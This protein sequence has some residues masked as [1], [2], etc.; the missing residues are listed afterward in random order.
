MTCRQGCW[1]IG[2]IATLCLTRPLHAQHFGGG[3]DFE[4]LGLRSLARSLGVGPGPGYHA[5]A[6]GPRHANNYY[7]VTQGASGYP[8]EP[9]YRPQ[10]YSEGAYWTPPHQSDQNSWNLRYPQH[11][12]A[13]VAPSESPNSQEP[14][15]T[16]EKPEPLPPSTRAPSS[17]A[18]DDNAEGSLIDELLK[19]QD[20]DE[21][22]LFDEL[23]PVSPSDLPT[24]A[25]PQ[26]NNISGPG[27]WW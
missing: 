14:K 1:A 15:R 13:P 20:E 24:P 2:L 10:L 6:C 26:A 22:D 12:T 8:L 3:Y 16:T 4:P 27:T 17:K 21:S 25:P 23:Q 7:R 18:E 5:P 11:P 9:D 19:E